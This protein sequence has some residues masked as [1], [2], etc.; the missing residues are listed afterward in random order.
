MGHPYWP[1]F[2]LRLTVGELEL[3]PLIEADLVPLIDLLPPDV[4]IDPRLPDLGGGDERRRA[5]AAHQSY[6]S[7]LG[8]WRP[9]RWRLGFAVRVGGGYAGAQE[10]EAERFA[11]RRTVET[12][13]WLGTAWRGRGIGK[14]MRIAVL[15]LAF[16]GLGAQV[17][18]TEAWHDNAAS[19]GVSRSLG[20]VE[21]G[22]GRQVRGDRADD[23][24]RMRLT[25][26]AWLTRHAGHGVRI[27]G[28][29]GCRAF[30][31]VG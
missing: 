15:A 5:A 21:N 13:S 19:L 30:F 1:V 31:G 26:A 28:L 9:D 25:R 24:P 18:E 12:A 23:M 17:A 6:W 8:S 16:D 4:E 14:A 7:S 27:D 29:A 10:I 22:V 3:R 2:D 11:V 20:Y